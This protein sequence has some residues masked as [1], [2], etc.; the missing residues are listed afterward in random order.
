MVDPETCMKDET[1]YG[2]GYLFDV[3]ASLSKRHIGTFIRSDDGRNVRDG[4]V[5]MN[6]D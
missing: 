3:F 1:M 2:P 6:P 5:N 4:I